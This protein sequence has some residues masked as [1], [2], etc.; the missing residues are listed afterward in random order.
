MMSSMTGAAEVIAGAAIAAS[1]VFVVLAVQ[2]RRRTQ[3]KTARRSK[4]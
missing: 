4:P 2:E 1:A 3:S